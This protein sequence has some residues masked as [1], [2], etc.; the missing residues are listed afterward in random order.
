[1]LFRS[2][3]LNHIGLNPNYKLMT[4]AEVTVFL[5]KNL[6]LFN[7]KY[8]RPLG[9]PNK[10]LEAILQHFSRL[11]DEDVAPNQYIDWAKTQMSKLKCQNEEEKIES[12]KNLELAHVY[13]LYEQLKIKEGFFDFSDLIYYLLKLFRTRKNILE[14]YRR[15]FSHVLVD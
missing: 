8:F 10:F 7:L 13:R 14:K 2:E 5:K 4:E 1:M 15:Q 9:N 3:E 6:F 12:E 11:K